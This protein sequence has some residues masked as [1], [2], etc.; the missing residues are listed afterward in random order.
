MPFMTVVGMT[1]QSMG[2]DAMSY[3]TQKPRHSVALN[4]SLTF[5]NAYHSSSK[6]IHLTIKAALGTKP[7]SL[8]V[9][10]KSDLSQVFLGNVD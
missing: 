2:D 5:L 9:S 7:A 10:P 3:L 8:N 4:S 6:C 1:L